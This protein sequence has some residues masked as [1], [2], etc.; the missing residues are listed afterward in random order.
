MYNTAQS[1]ET[2]PTFRRDMSPSCACF[3]P[4]SCLAYS[5]LNM[6]ATCSCE[7]SVDF[8]RAT[9]C[10]IPADWTFHNHHFWEPQILHVKNTIFWDVMPCSPVEAYRRFGGVLSPSSASKN[11]PM[12]QAARSKRQIS[13]NL[14]LIQHLSLF[15]FGLH[16]S[17]SPPWPY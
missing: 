5:T 11:K 10:Y 15:L 17:N 14:S 8:Q 6:E 13:A 4:V 3:S 7:T 1:F 12:K 2:Q 16:Q 9:R